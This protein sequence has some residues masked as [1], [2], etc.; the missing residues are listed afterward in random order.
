MDFINNFFRI[1]VVLDPNIG[2]SI[3]L[4]ICF[5]LHYL[6]EESQWQSAWENVLCLIFVLR[7]LVL[8]SLVMRSLPTPTTRG[9]RRVTRET[10][11]ATFL[12]WNTTKTLVRHGNSLILT[13]VVIRKNQIIIFNEMSKLTIQSHNREFSSLFKTYQSSSN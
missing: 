11:I 7:S 9:K 13:D 5:L 2:N 10:L 6:I 1:F 12:V 4:S 8:R 3:Y